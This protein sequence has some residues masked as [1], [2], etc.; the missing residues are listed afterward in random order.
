MRSS[1]KTN[2]KVFYIK[3]RNLN[4][5]IRNFYEKFGKELQT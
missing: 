3:N 4:K 2:N 5:N 1:Q